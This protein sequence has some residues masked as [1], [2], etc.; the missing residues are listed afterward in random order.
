[1]TIMCPAVASLLTKLPA[2][3]KHTKHVVVRNRIGCE[4]FG[5]TDNLRKTGIEEFPAERG[6]ENGAAY[7]DR[8]KI[9]NWT[10][11]SVVS[12]I[13]EQ[14]LISSIWDHQLPITTF[15]LGMILSKHRESLEDVLLSYVFG[16]LI[17]EVLTSP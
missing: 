12:R 17:T 16:T 4:R 3:L 5:N 15:S 1:N 11:R 14:H 8:I 10:I 13:P 9:L 7:F 2:G 6:K